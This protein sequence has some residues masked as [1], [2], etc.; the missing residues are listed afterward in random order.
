MRVE[1]E[2]TAAVII[3]IQERLFPHMAGAE[4]LLGNTEILIR[5]LI[6]LGIP[7]VY[8]EQYPRG[9]GSTIP[10]INALLEGHEPVEK[11]AFSC[12]DEPGF[13]SRL[14]EL[15]RKHIVLAGIEAHVCVLQTCLD[16]MAGAY[17][18]VVI[19]DCISSR[20]LSDKHTAVSR[21][22]Q[23]GA[24]VSSYESILFELCRVSGSDEFKSISRLVK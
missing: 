5:G 1:R 10:E 16:L 3:D 19:E 15:D 9:L 13:I 20:K 12:C 8:T 7:L 23:E 2:H 24:L 21:M 22:R 4:E 17:V 14:K 11:M 6:T 18:P